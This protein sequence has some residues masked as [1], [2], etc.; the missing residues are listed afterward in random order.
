LAL[1][2]LKEKWNITSNFQ[3]LIIFVVF[4]I[5]GSLSVR[6]GQPVLHFLHLT[7]NSF[8]SLPLGTALYWVLRIL[9]I[10]P[11][12]QVLL[13]VVGTIFLQ[14]RFFWEFE[15]KILRRMGFKKQFPEN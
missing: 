11:L 5:T 1:K 10:F 3:L 4:G 6:L 9:I 7:P 8:T 2:K 13:L 15:K 12:Y 14:F